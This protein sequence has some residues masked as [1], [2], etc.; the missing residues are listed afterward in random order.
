MSR[1]GQFGVFEGLP[2]LYSLLLPNGRAFLFVRIVYDRLF[3]Y[4][5]STVA[6]TLLIIQGPLMQCICRPHRL[7]LAMKNYIAWYRLWH[8]SEI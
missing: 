6:A 4:I 1:R 8:S 3:V 5:I 7:F 2:C